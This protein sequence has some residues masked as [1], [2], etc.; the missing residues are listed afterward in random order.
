MKK[1]TIEFRYD[2]KSDRYTQA[3]RPYMVDVFCPADDKGKPDRK[4][5]TRTE[6]R[7]EAKE[8]GAVAVFVK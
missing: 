1:P 8:R 3:N 2:G 4:R 5:L 7:S 6:A